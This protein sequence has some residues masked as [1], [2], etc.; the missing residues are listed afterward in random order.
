MQLLILI[1]MARRGL[2]R[3]VTPCHRESVLLGPVGPASWQ[4]HARARQ[5]YTHLFKC[6]F[7]LLYMGWSSRM[8]VSIW[9]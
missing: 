6:T 1:T 7:Q 5:L 4:T 2:M 8:P 9:L 3:P